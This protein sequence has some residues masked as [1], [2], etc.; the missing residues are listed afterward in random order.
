MKKF[1]FTYT[2]YLLLP[3]LAFQACN[4]DDIAEESLYTFTDQ[5]MGQYLKEDTV[6][7]KQ[8]SEFVRLL[9]TT[10][11]MGL[12]NSYGVYTCFA[13]TNEAFQLYYASKG[14]TSMKDFSLETLK[15]IAYDHL[16]NGSEITGVYF[17]NTLSDQTMNDKYITMDFSESGILI[18][19]SSKVIKKDILV[20]NGVLHIIDRV[21]DPNRELLSAAIASDSTFVIFARALELTGM[22]DSL[23]LEK[24]LTYN[25]LNYA[26]LVTT[27]KEN[28]AWYYTPVPHE[29]YYGYT[30]L[31]ESDATYNAHQIFTLNDLKNYAKSVYDEIFPEDASIS[32]PTSRR[33]SLNRFVSYHLI[34]KKL[35]SSKFINDYDTDHMIKTVDMQEY[36]EPMCPN[37][38]IEVYKERTT[39]KSNLFNFVDKD[40]S[41]VVSLVTSNMDNI[42]GNGV[43]HEIDNILVYSKQV[44]DY[45]SSKRL[46]FE[47]ASFFPELT[48][49]NMRGSQFKALSKGDY[50]T[51]D[52]SVHWQLP[53]NY[54]DRITSSEQTVVGYLSGYPSF[55]D[56]MGDEIFLAASPGKLYDFS[57]T[58]L[59]VPAGTY[60]VRFGYQVNG[61]RGVA[62][63]YLD[64]KPCGV[65]LNLNN[66]GD[67]ASIGYI[68]PSVSNLDDP[69]GFENDKMMR[70]RGYMKAP[71]TFLPVQK[72]WYPAVDARHDRTTLRRIMGTYTFTKSSNHIMTVKGLSAGEFMFD[73]LEFV[74]VSVIESEDIY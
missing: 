53:R 40:L 44:E 60:E 57:I 30:A 8:F 28:G 67:N 13:P 24:D 15:M 32:D 7:N 23:T 5:M 69:F 20:H 26:S 38:L 29:R 49:N 73:Y 59:P 22:S 10:K 37:T 17:A 63:L 34:N 9:D 3:V 70:N 61:K 1:I 16:I 14:K 35:T 6:N 50:T 36:I 45:L 43:Y 68:L 21:L 66:S 2:I 65:P 18:Y 52:Q 33:N 74:P 51:V 47:A 4:S 31:I 55:D 62:Q 39:K 11:V 42:S 12:L 46:R 58:T 64:G 71:E 27:P 41:K 25:W 72:N 54:I 48:N 19:K 56:Y